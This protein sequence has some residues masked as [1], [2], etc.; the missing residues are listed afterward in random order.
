MTPASSSSFGRAVCSVALALT[1]VLQPLLSTAHAQDAP[2]TVAPPVWE[3][4]QL[5]YTPQL[6][7][8]SGALQLSKQQV[9]NIA[10]EDAL[11]HQVNTQQDWPLLMKMALITTLAREAPEK[12]AEEIAKAANEFEKTFR[13]KLATS[14]TGISTALDLPAELMGDA[15]DVV[16]D[17]LPEDAGLKAKVLV[18]LTQKATKWAPRAYNAVTGSQNQIDAQE[19]VA[20]QAAAP[21]RFQEQIVREFREV[22]GQN[23]ARGAARLTI[24]QVVGVTKEDSAEKI[25]RTNAVLGVKAKV[26]ETDERVRRLSDDVKA[27]YELLANAIGDDG[28]LTLKLEELRALATTQFS[29]MNRRLTDITKSI[30]DVSKKQDAIIGFLVQKEAQERAAEEAAAKREQDQYLRELEQQ[31]QRS[32]VFLV[33][34][35]FKSVDPQFGERFEVVANT[36]LNVVAALEKF[37]NALTNGA[38]TAG[39]VIL[40]GN[41]LGAGLAIAGLF[42]D[43]GPSTDELIMKQLGQI[44]TAVNTMRKEMH[45]RFDRVDRSLNTIYTEMITG[46]NNLYKYAMRLEKDIAKNRVLLGQAMTALDT[47]DARLVRIEQ[48]IDY[49]Y[50]D[51]VDEQTRTTLNQCLRAT[52]LFPDASITKAQFTNCVFAFHTLA[53]AKASA[54]ILTNYY[55]QLPS[56]IVTLTEQ[57]RRPAV[58][59]VN[60]LRLV[61][62]MPEYQ[63]EAT[64]V[65]AGRE[66]P[67]AMYWAAGAQ[68]METLL[69]R[70][71]S[72]VADANQAQLQSIVGEITRPGRDLQD[73][74]AALRDPV[75]LK[76]VLAAYDAAVTRALGDDVGLLAVWRRAVT[77]TLAAELQPSAE[78]DR[79]SNVN[80][81]R[82][83]G[84][85]DLPELAFNDAF[86]AQLP[87]EYKRAYQLRLSE[88]QP[89]YQVESKI[90]VFRRAQFDCVREKK[91]GGGTAKDGDPQYRCEE[92]R[93]VA[94]AL[95][96]L[97]FEVRGSAMIAYKT[98][99]KAVIPPLPP[100]MDELGFP[101]PPFVPVSMTQ[102]ATI[103]SSDWT[104][105]GH[106][107]PYVAKNPEAT[108]FAPGLCDFDSFPGSALNG[109][110]GNAASY[111]S[112]IKWQVDAAGV[113]QARAALAEKV[114][115]READLYAKSL[116]LF[117]NRVRDTLARTDEADLE[118]AKAL[119]ELD[120]RKR[121]LDAVLR[122]GFPRSF[123]RSDLIRGNLRSV[124]G[125]LDSDT[126]REIFV[127]SDDAL[128]QWFVW[129]IDASRALRAENP[130]LAMRRYIRSVRDAMNASGKT[131]KSF[132]EE[133]HLVL[134]GQPH[135]DRNLVYHGL[136]QYHRARFDALEGYVMRNRDAMVSEESR[137][138]V[139]STL[140]EIGMLRSVFFTSGPVG[141]N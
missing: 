28:S 105:T 119:R 78:F 80:K 129:P 62:V 70:N 77:E 38:V 31:A 122:A 43:K 25:F 91:V 93:R 111:A 48:K 104:T 44:L 17:V 137:D 56:D 97:P 26:A 85:A 57:L 7:S 94:D 113:E 69:L 100:Q 23:N 141:T 49:F 29:R 59:N 27:Q 72:L 4:N 117:V 83:C 68:G 76:K 65:L 109:I 64:K 84:S 121:I 135:P 19:E 53:T 46:F 89:C 136:T 130:S 8:P 14:E 55:P 98:E 73:Y 101:E 32:G 5:P 11:L 51:V 139:A 87:V 124:H 9:D 118:L 21:L 128:A 24:D 50:Q 108:Q 79:P 3:S 75:F 22:Q 125:L 41:L 88:L 45:D 131:P 132:A 47:I 126:L 82:Y 99:T 34:T 90:G 102:R 107:F 52:E 33:S 54:R 116:T 13:E 106:R 115:Q 123:E 114:A 134:A 140:T 95:C 35:L 86:F 36:T 112:A 81:I 61:A 6:A 74:Y 39:S 30:G 96:D 12:P 15:L 37:E 10:Y 42:A 60:L 71:A 2:P 67:H 110:K 18:S 40:T 58:S 63:T 103:L 127:Q 16:K 92:W 1:L 120:F 138:L 20:R 133:M 66:L